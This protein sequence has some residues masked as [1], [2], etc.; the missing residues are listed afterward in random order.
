M[1]AIQVVDFARLSKVFYPVAYRKI[2][3]ARAKAKSFVYYTTAE[4]AESVIKYRQVWMRNALS[5]NDYME[6]DHGRDCLRDAL[7][8]R[9]GVRMKAALDAAHAGIWAQSYDK[10]RTMLPGIK[11]DTYIT[12]V[13][14]HLTKERTLGRLSMWRAYGAKSGVALVLNSE[15]ILSEE[16]VVGAVSS[17]VEY[18]DS[19]GF[20]RAMA[21]V[22]SG[23]HAERDFL[24]TIPRPLLERYIFEML[25]YAVLCVKHPGFAEEREWR[26]FVTN[27]LQHS[28]VLER[29][30][31]TVRGTPQHVLKIPMC[32]SVNSKLK[33]SFA[34]VVQG[35]I[36]GPC[37]FPDIAARAF[38]D[39]LVGAGMDPEDA[40][41]RVSISGIPLRHL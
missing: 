40:S 9:V 25:R 35:V 30:V 19:A 29:T 33:R 2:Q 17:P 24:A 27:F 32:K 11:R 37:A 18:L 13:S 6:I 3:G 39:L 5:M 8:S 41:R 38:Q 21:N 14:E 20:R 28:D 16:S 22:A 1:M 10:F 7:E 12:C 4:V 26:I 36:I 23:L 31:H 15:A 34:D